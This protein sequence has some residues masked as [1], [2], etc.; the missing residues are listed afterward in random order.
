MAELFIGGDFRGM[1]MK[2]A[3]LNNQK[4]FGVVIFQ[5]QLV[6]QYC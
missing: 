2:N 5:V 4:H 1:E 6:S 3:V